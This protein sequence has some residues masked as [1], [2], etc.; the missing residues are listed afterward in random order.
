MYFTELTQ[1]LYSVL[2]SFSKI[3]SYPVLLSGSVFGPNQVLLVYPVSEK[4]GLP[5]ILNPQHSMLYISIF[6]FQF[7]H[8]SFCSVPCGRL[9]WL[10]VSFWAHVNRPYI[11]NRI[12]S[13]VSYQ[14][15]CIVLYNAFQSARHPKVPLFVGGSNTWFLGP[16][17]VNIPNSITVG[18][19][20]TVMTCRHT[21]RPTVHSVAIGYIQLV[22]RC[23]LKILARLQLALTSGV[24]STSLGCRR[25]QSG[26][27]KTRSSKF[28]AY[29]IMLSVS[30]SSVLMQNTPLSVRPGI[31]SSSS[32]HVPLH[33]HE[34]TSSSTSSHCAP[35]VATR[36]P[37]TSGTQMGIQSFTSAT[38]WVHNMT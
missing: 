23:G 24:I 15:Y 5:S 6:W 34:Q 36:S 17:R 12:V 38:K 22:M 2:R 3:S 21:D 16:T 7:L 1:V 29:L 33:A 20:L 27:D 32:M 9:S 31:G 30:V 26:S 28:S 25:L 8:Y 10:L 35:S 14:S 13:I 37:T 4:N 18:S 19:E 11:V